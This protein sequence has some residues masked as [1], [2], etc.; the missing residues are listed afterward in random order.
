MLRIKNL[1]NSPYSIQLADG[2]KVTLPARGTLDAV[3]V[4]PHHL[5]LYRSIGYF[6]IEEVTGAPEPE[7][8]DLDGL[9]D[10]YKEL[11]GKDA[12]GRWKAERIQ[13][14]IDKALEG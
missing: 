3:D 11:T 14:E 9:R 4:H 5:P 7:T 13:S 10:E 2:T 12:D 6:Q 8:D 1:I